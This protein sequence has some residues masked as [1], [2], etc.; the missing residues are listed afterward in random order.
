MRTKLMLLCLLQVFTSKNA[1]QSTSGTSHVKKHLSKC[2][3]QTFITTEEQK[4]LVNVISITVLYSSV[5]NLTTA[6]MHM[7]S[8]V[9]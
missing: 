8:M 6:D 5:S 7:Y 1:F 9:C 3:S 4:I 2:I